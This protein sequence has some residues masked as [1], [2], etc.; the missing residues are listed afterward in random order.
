LVTFWAEFGAPRLRQPKSVRFSEQLRQASHYSKNIMPIMKDEEI[1]LPVANNDTTKASTDEDSSTVGSESHSASNDKAEVV[2]PTKVVA[3][4]ASKRRLGLWILALFFLT[5]LAAGV[6]V[7]WMKSREDESEMTGTS[8]SREQNT[9]DTVGVTGEVTSWPDLVGMNADAA[10]AMLETDY[11]GL[12]VVVADRSEAKALKQQ[13]YDPNRV[14]LV[15]CSG[16]GPVV[17]TPMVG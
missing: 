11:P 17:K 2:K 5:C 15:T 4:P 13:G 8:L 1:A 9:T 12:Q 10:R 16:R 14:I 7:G 6:A 3:V